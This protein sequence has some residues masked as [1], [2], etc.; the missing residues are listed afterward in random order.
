MSTIKTLGLGSIIAATCVLQSTNALA[1]SQP[2]VVQ[3]GFW[4]NVSGLEVDKLT[5]LDAYPD[6]PDQV[7]EL[8]ELRSPQN[9]G[10]NYGSLVRGYIVPPSTGRYTFFVAGDDETQ[11]WLSPSENPAAAELTA[12][13]TGW[14]TPDQYTKYGSQA[15]GVLE[16]SAGQRY[17]FEIR[18]KERSGG[19]HFS[20]A[21]EGPGIPQQVIG[22][23][24]IASLGQSGSTT[25]PDQQSIE[26]AYAQGYRVGF[27][28]GS[29]GLTFNSQYPMLDADRDG[30]Y[31]NWEILH[32]LDAGNPGDAGSDP[33]NDMLMALD[34]FL[35]GTRENNPDSDGDGIPDGVEFADGLDPLDPSDASQDMDGDG[36]SNL[37][38]HLANTDPG[39][40]ADAPVTAAAQVSGF[41]GQYF[42]GTGFE[43]F[44][45]TRQDMQIDFSWGSGQPMAELPADN[46]SVRWSGM[47][48]APH[49]DG[50]EQY[51]FPTL[52][53]DDVRASLAGNLVINE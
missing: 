47:F 4:D 38:E 41:I 14:T 13:V 19:D 27:L 26:K 31:D 52:T 28:D 9:R 1:F 11:F 32:G 5:V 15:S 51:Q 37:E 2:G 46:F 12:S 29:E 34:E 35:L 39:N 30:I 21:W 16:L 43:R 40:P 6:K 22:G 7:I 24:A 10:D 3:A 42:E 20:V 33:D 50:T 49:S 53:G 25:T 23:S 36:F 17:Y 8:T 44:V 18:H 48:T 45:R